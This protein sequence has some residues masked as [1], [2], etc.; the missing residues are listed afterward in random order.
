MIALTAPAGL[1]LDKLA[2]TPGPAHEEARTFCLDTIMEFYGVGYRADWHADLDSLLLPAGQ[3]HYSAL[4][5]G[6]FWLLREAGGRVVGSAGV[7]HLAWKP[8]IAEMFPGRYEQATAIASLWR[9]YV[10]SNMRGCG[11]GRW[12]VGLSEDEA[13]RAGYRTMYLHATS[14]AA[15]TVAFW[16]SV[17]YAEVGTCATSTHFE[18]PLAAVPALP[19]A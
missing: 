3:N 7:R 2:D 4:N 5:R 11:V 13:A 16:R 14:D 15:A 10:R 12:L 17:G 19:D 9:V 1:T 18:K 8:N 6:G